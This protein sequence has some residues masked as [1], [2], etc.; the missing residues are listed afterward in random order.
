MDKYAIILAA[1]IGKRMNS[2]IPKCA[3]KLNGKSMINYIIE[4]CLECEFN[5]IYVVVGHNKDYLINEIKYS[6]NYVI[7]EKQLGT[8]HA[9]L[10]C[11]QCFKNKEGIVIILN[12]DTPLIDSDIINN[13]INYHLNK[14][15]DFTIVSTILNDPL[16]Y[17]RVYVKDGYVK[18][19]IEYKDCNNN[20][21]KINKINCGLYCINLEILFNGLKLIKNN[22]NV[23]EYYFT[24]LIEILEQDYKIGCY[25]IEDSFK[26]I[27]I[28][29]QKTLKEVEEEIKKRSN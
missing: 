7:Q 2:N 27:G 19:I 21:K 18:K 15:N 16:Q 25:N 1:G 3:I 12:G 20:Q 6:V 17:G 28:N 11:E 26:M 14:H 5:D 9:V 13:L 24:D 4:T 29:D 10:C 23:K 8:G 22:N